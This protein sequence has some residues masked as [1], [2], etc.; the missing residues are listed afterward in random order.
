MNKIL[1]PIHNGQSVNDSIDFYIKEN[2]S[3]EKLE[4][5]IPIGTPVIIEGVF[6]QRPELRKYFDFVIYIN[7][8][9]ET[10]LK[11]VLERDTYIGNAKEIASKY[12]RR[13]FPAEQKYLEQCKPLALADVIEDNVEERLV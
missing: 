5:D 11:R 10:R 13:Y 9:K 3:Y 12:E 7:A 8:T 6:L 2:D 4:I 1:S